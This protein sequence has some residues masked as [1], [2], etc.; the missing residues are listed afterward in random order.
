MKTH[1][2]LSGFEGT[3]E[4]EKYAL[5]KFATIRKHIPAAERAQSICSVVLTRKGKGDLITSNCHITVEVAESAF[6]TDEKTRHMYA[7]IDIAVAHMSR[8]LDFHFA[9]TKKPSMRKR[10]QHKLNGRSPK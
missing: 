1:L 5:R 10:L 6:N 4:L 7:A 3:P 2:S 8:Q 9:Q